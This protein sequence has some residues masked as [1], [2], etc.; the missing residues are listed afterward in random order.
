MKVI[1]VI[2]LVVTMVGGFCLEAMAQFAKINTSLED[3]K[4]ITKVDTEEIE[5]S[6]ARH[7]NRKSE[8]VRVK[9]QVQN[10]SGANVVSNAGEVNSG[11]N[12]LMGGLTKTNVNNFQSQQQE[13]TGSKVV[14]PNAKYGKRSLAGALIKASLGNVQSQQQEQTGTTG[15]TT[16]AGIKSGTPK[17][18]KIG[19]LFKAGAIAAGKTAEVSASGK[20]ISTQSNKIQKP[21]T[22]KINKVQGLKALK[23]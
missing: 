5:V 16:A 22:I 23:Y 6:G 14:L 15:E 9:T 20:S 18:G 8:R 17:P 13:Q 1:L 2:L 7:Y 19:G 10:A 12:T 11:N 3:I 4:E 21:G